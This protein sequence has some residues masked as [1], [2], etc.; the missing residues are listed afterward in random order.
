MRGRSRLYVPIGSAFRD[1]RVTKVR[2]PLSIEQAL[3]DVIDALGMSRAAEVTGRRQSYLRRVTDPARRDALTCHDALLLDAEY[4]ATVGGRPIHETMKVKLDAQRLHITFD[5]QAL[6]E[7]TMDS[8]REA[9]GAH[10]ALIAATA[11][12]SPSVLKAAL[13]GLMQSVQAKN[14][15]API[16][17][18]MIRRQP[19]AP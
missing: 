8:V 19:Q 5:Q 6:L 4:D 7:A 14:R 3:C 9:G 18:Q 10:A 12:P 17:R 15:I 11:H 1:A 13:R 2:Q 16:L